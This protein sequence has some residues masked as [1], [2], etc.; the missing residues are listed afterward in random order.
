MIRPTRFVP[1][2]W[3]IALIAPQPTVHAGQEPAVV[4]PPVVATDP[5]WEVSMIMPGWL[6]GIDGTIGVRGI[7]THTEAG[8]D[9]ILKNLDMIGAATLEA[10]RGKLGFILDGMY[11]KASV[12]GDPPGQL[13]SNVSVSVEQVLAE[14]ALTYRFYESDRARLEI[15]AGARYFYMGTELSLALDPA[16]V[17]SVSNTLADRI[18]DRG[19][20]AAKKEVQSRLP[21]LV[22]RLESEI[23]DLKANA[24]SE[25]EDRVHEKVEAVKEAIRDRIDDGIGSGDPGF[26]VGISQ[27][28]PI[29]D[30]IRDY[31]SAKVNAEIEAARAQA[32]AAVAEARARIRR[33]AERRLEQAEKRLAKAI[34]REINDRVPK[35]PVAASKAWTDPFIGFRGRCELWEDWHLVARGDIGGFGVSSDLTW[36]AF[37]A[38]GYALNDRTTMEIGYRYLSVDYSSGSFTYDMVTKGPYLGLRLD[39]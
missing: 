28:G 9:D 12:G 21:G 26:G 27:S 38:I 8:I 39:F 23:A 20:E 11:L 22:A 4:E 17:R 34:E 7:E 19:S 31:V 35:N 37:G 16:G 25:I 2:L 30:T 14:G 33:E 10:R 36:N 5:G 3:S 32:S 1:L 13:I 15:I 6:A 24:V 29:R 18:L